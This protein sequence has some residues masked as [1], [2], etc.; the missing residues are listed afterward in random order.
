M[1]KNRLV[2][3]AL[4]VV[5]VQVVKAQEVNYSLVKPV[6]VNSKEVTS[7]KTQEQVKTPETTT[8]M[9]TTTYH[10]KNIEYYTKF[11]QALEVKKEAMKSSP[12][13]NTKAEETG[14]YE[15]IDKEIAIAKQELLKLEDNE[16]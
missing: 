2:L 5:G 8:N 10:V 15:K 12:Y 16:K 14:W 7:K 1:K 11:I 3:F 9:V 4:L 13:Y 6:V